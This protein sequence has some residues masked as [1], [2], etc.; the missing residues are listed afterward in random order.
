MT[1]G[2]KKIHAL[3]VVLAL[4][5]A[6]CSPTKPPVDELNAASRALAAARQADAAQYAAPEYRSASRHF[7][8]AQA[9]ERQQ[10]YDVAAQLAA[11]SQADSELALAKARLAKARAAVDKLKQDNA[12]LDRDLNSHATAEQQP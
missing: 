5:G 11:E 10:D 12:D 2:R 4:L 1:S 3:F 7:D 9:A 8:D 6:G